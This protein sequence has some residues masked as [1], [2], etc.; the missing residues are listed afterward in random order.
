MRKKIKQRERVCVYACVCMRVRNRD[1]RVGFNIKF[2]SICIELLNF[3]T[4]VID[5]SPLFDIILIFL[6][7]F[8]AIKSTNEKSIE[9]TGQ[10]YKKSKSSMYACVDVSTKLRDY[11]TVPDEPRIEE[12]KRNVLAL[13]TSGFEFSCLD[14]EPHNRTRVKPNK[15]KQ[16]QC[17]KIDI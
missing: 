7:Q 11:K 14:R 13:Y 12:G 5:F 17:Q 2:H 1:Q 6:N 3:S 10:T 16:K 9:T 15:K 4:I 8:F